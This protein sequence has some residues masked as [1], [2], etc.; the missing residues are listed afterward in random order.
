MLMLQ[1]GRTIIA[2]QVRTK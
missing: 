1:D 2:V